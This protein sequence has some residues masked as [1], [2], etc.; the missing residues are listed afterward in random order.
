[1][2]IIY[3]QYKFL[4]DVLLKCLLAFCGTEVI[5]Y[6]NQK[7]NGSMVKGLHVG[8]EN[9]SHVMKLGISYQRDSHCNMWEW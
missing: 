7:F 2:F 9:T 5:P 6:I 1:L 3:F 4:N 8:A